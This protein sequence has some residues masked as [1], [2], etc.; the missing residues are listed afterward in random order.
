MNCHNTT[1]SRLSSV[2]A[3]RPL[4]LEW[5]GGEYRACC[6]SMCMVMLP[7]SPTV[8]LFI[9]TRRGTAPGNFSSYNTV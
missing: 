8:L 4:S 9:H 7:A 6:H 1:N 5:R 2:Q 3:H